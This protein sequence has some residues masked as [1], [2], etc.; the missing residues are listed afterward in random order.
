[1]AKC[2]VALL[3]LVRLPSSFCV[4]VLCYRHGVSLQFDTYTERRDWVPPLLYVIARV[5]CRMSGYKR[6]LKSSSER[7]RGSIF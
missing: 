3:F 1:M 5:C 6:K 2:T 4:Q 7:G